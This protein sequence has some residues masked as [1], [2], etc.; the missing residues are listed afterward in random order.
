MTKRVKANFEGDNA[1][2]EAAPKKPRSPRATKTPKSSQPKSGL[3]ATSPQFSTVKEVSVRSRV[4][5]EILGLVV[6]SVGGLLCFTIY[7]PTQYLG[8]MG[9]LLKT[10]LTSQINWGMYLLPIPFMVY[11]LAIFTLHPLARL[12]R[13][14]L[15]LVVLVFASMV[16]ADI[17]KPGISGEAVRDLGYTLSNALG[18]VSL[19]LPIAIMGLGLELILGLKPFLLARGFLALLALLALRIFRA[20]RSITLDASSATRLLGRRNSV[21]GK[22]EGYRK[23]LVAIAQLYP[24]SQELA[25]W[26]AESNLAAQNIAVADTASLEQIEL[27]IAAWQHLVGEFASLRAGDLRKDLADENQRLPEELLQPDE[28]LQSVLPG[29]LEVTNLLEQQRRII[30]LEGSKLQASAQKLLAERERTEKTLLETLSAGKLE[31]E[32]NSHQQRLE[33][34]KNL[35]ASAKNW[36]ARSRAVLP[37]VAFAQELEQNPA[38]DLYLEDLK[39]A[40]STEPQQT[41]EDFRA[42]SRSLGVARQQH[43]R[44]LLRVKAQENERKDLEDHND[45]DDHETSLAQALSGFSGHTLGHIAGHASGSVG[46]VG[47]SKNLGN[48]GNTGVSLEPDSEFLPSEQ[49]ETEEDNW[50]TTSPLEVATIIRQRSS[51]K[52]DVL[53]W[54]EAPLEGVAANRPSNPNNQNNQKSDQTPAP[55]PAVGGIP[56]EKPK[57]DLLDPIPPLPADLQTLD[58]HAQSRGLLIDQAFVNFKVNAKVVDFSRGPTVTRYEIEPA[59]GEKIA[60][61]SNLS[62]DLARVL[63]V[64]GVRVEGNIPGKNVVGL[65]VPNAVREPVAFHATAISAAFR[66]SKA[67]LPLIIG[68]TID[69]EI[70]V[71]DLAKMPHL[72]I[73]GS[74]GSGKSVCVNTLITSML[75]RYLPQELRFIMIDPKMVELTPYD[76]IPH[77]IRPVVTN[78]ADAAGVLLGCVAHMERRYKM[79]SK[80]GAKNLEQYN[81]KAKQIGEPELPLIVMIIDELA[82]LMITSPKEVESAIM[83]L[84]Q[85]ARATGMHLMLAT[86]RPSVDI[87]TSLI[88]VNVPARIAFAVSSSH[89]SRTILDT[90][91]AERLVGMGD[92]LFFQPGLGKPLRLQAPY[93]SEE[94]STRISDFLRRQY[95]DDD[96]GTAYGSDFDGVMGLEGEGTHLDK[97]K[98]DF[99]D[100]LLRQAAE[101]VL[102]EGQGSV[103]RLQRRLSVGHARAG[104]LMDLLEAMGIVSGNKGSKPRDVLITAADMPEYFGR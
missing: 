90:M 50:D 44:E 85:M 17:L 70:F 26:Q 53:P 91:G 41:L 31:R 59:P 40:L 4:L 39:L 20:F 30:M 83:R 1:V 73:A 14:V 103:S 3:R 63:A 82:D 33:S 43:E 15:G 99:S 36:L 47:N 74:T 77:L 46:N 66:Q 42:W 56:V 86:Q 18:R 58:K 69:G 72:L 78:P 35:Q 51:L 57:A 52:N 9:S 89:D 62:N 16:A 76:G 84:A 19:V 34:W 5:S 65:E 37:W 100:P 71:G 8:G 21:R 45:I 2:A 24:K 13:M 10:Y 95:F 94:E 64:S 97:G 81:A 38:L 7:F 48:S 28:R 104:K 102:E 88:K 101:I 49:E 23:N 80:I 6:L 92:L 22:L 96:F 29:R 55:L 54:E 79:M 75:F 98:M 32:L 93:I 61:I 25:R 87:L 11:G 60:R 67:K 12:T 27:E 68:K